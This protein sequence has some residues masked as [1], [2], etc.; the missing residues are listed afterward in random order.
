[1]KD[2]RNEKKEAVI[3]RA[4]K[5]DDADLAQVSGGDIEPYIDRSQYCLNRPGLLHEWRPIG[6]N[7]RKCIRCQKEESF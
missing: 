6:R 2:I 5:L 7:I 3:S 1:M 4:T